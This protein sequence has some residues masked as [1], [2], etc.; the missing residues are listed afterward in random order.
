MNV[1]HHQQSKAQR[2]WRKAK[3]K[4]KTY[5]A[6]NHQNDIFVQLATLTPGSVIV[7]RLR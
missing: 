5:K 2:S 4:V 7:S 1:R 3:E 6:D